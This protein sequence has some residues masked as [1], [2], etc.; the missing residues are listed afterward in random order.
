MSIAIQR[1]GDQERRQDQPTVK[2]N[3][4]LKLACDEL[5]RIGDSLCN[6]TRIKA[7]ARG[8]NAIN[9]EFETNIDLHAIRKIKFDDFKNNFDRQISAQSV[10]NELKYLA[11]KLGLV[12]QYFNISVILQTLKAH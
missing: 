7:N 12:Q 1:Q 11:K 6:D 8:V 10:G 4:S 5:E 3:K 2:L 9:R